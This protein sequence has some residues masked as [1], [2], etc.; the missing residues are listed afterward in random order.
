MNINKGL[1]SK[2]RFEYFYSFTEKPQFEYKCTN[3]YNLNIKKLTTSGAYGTVSTVCEG[4]KCDYIVKAI[5]LKDDSAKFG[6]LTEALILPIMSREGI[7]PKLKEIFVCLNVG[8]I[9]ME[10]WDGSFKELIMDQSVNEIKYIPEI[11]KL[12]KKMH[13]KKIIHNDLHMG[14]ILWKKDEK[15]NYKF[16]IIDFGYSVYFENKNYIVPINYLASNKIP[17]I[18]LPA[19]DYYRFSDRLDKDGKYFYTAIY[20]DNILSL[21]DFLIIKK[22]HEY[23]ENIQRTSMYVK[24][25]T[26]YDFINKYGY[27]K[28][29]AENLNKDEYSSSILKKT[30]NYNNINYNKK[31]TI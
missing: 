15:N 12:V 1:L 6:F 27:T 9:V 28:V 31:Y 26:F 21:K 18:F 17:N 14:N 20:E 4:K 10:K 23:V 30:K 16:A 22:Y 24:E 5:P 8:F 25:I 13:K 3:N 19:Y 29:L 7:S 2:K 11:F